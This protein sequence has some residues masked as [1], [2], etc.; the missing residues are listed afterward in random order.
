MNSTNYCLIQ[1]IITWTRNIFKKDVRL[2]FNCEICFYMYCC[3]LHRVIPL[4]KSIIDTL[5]TQTVPYWAIVAPLQGFLNQLMA[6]KLKEYWIQI[7]YSRSLALFRTLSTI[8]TWINIIIF[9]CPKQSWETHFFLLFFFFL[10]KFCLA[11][12]SVAWLDGLF[13]NLGTWWDMD[14]KLCNRVLVIMAGS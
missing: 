2:H 7:H 12:I 10:P 5:T 11:K 9:K 8:I 3:L 6:L 4:G 13:W 14:M 1:A